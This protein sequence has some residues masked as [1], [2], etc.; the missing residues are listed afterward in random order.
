VRGDGG[1]QGPAVLNRR[2]KLS[3]VTTLYRSEPHVREFYARAVAA[4]ALLTTDV[5]VVFVNDG[6]P[7]ASLAVAVEL[8]GADPRVRVVDLSRNFGH[9]RAMMT[10]LAH[11]RGDLVFLIDC[12]LEEDPAL[13]GR[14]HAELQ[15]S[16]ADVV[17]GFQERRQGGLFKRWS[18]GVFYRVFNFL[19]DTKWPPNLCTVRLMTRRYVDSLLTYQERETSIAGLW[20]LTG[21]EQRGLPIVRSARRASTYTI[22]RR[23][24]IFID[25]VTS[26]SDRPLILVFYLGLLIS[27]VAGVAATYLVVRRLFFGTL[28]A[29]WPSVIV[30]IWLLGGLILFCL[31]LLG[32]YLSRIFL[33][34]KQRP[35]TIVRR[36][37]G[38]DA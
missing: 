35:Y 10:G 26:F 7:D 12:D 14:F 9:H 32:I 23:L 30:S 33:E 8:H 38:R 2:V 17:Y 29:G 11:A 36:L 5:E 3:V 31:G 4:A 13:V 37:Y 28:L 22:A 34:T 25:A 16:G 24:K 21:Y 19:A 27:G 15:Q 6:S 20:A 1:P 18:G